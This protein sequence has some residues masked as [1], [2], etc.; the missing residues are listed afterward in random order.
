[1]IS[2]LRRA[3]K[4]I[5][6]EDE[7]IVFENY[8]IFNINYISISKIQIFKIGKIGNNIGVW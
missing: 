8:I 3:E 7:E 5:Y 6:K 2:C 4:G 1:M